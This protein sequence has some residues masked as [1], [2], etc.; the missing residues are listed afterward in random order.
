MPSFRL[1]NVTGIRKPPELIKRFGLGDRRSETK[2]LL[3][4]LARAENGAALACISRYNEAYDKK[5]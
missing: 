1:R 4:T 2:R 5:M 3:G